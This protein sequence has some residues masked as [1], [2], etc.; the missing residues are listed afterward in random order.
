NAK[1]SIYMHSPYFIPD[2]GYV[3]ALRIAAKAGVDVRLIIP[4]K[5]DH[6]FVYWA[7]ITSVAQ[8]IRDGVKV[9]T[10]ENGFIHSKM[11]IIDDEVASVVSSNIDVRSFDLIVEIN[12]SMYDEKIVKELK[13]A[14]MEDLKVSEELTEARYEHRSTWIK[15]KQSIAKLASPIL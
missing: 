4:N 12:A 15:F 1:E 13:A 14:F 6:I 10:Y 3:N 7:T 8:L 11:M 9:Y 2:K 5:P